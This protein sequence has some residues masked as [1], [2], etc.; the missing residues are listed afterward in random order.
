[1]SDS[2][3]SLRAGGGAAPNL[4]GSLERPSGGGVAAS[5]ASSATPADVPRIG[6]RGIPDAFKANL[7]TVNQLIEFFNAI[8]KMLADD[9]LD[10]PKASTTLR[11]VIAHLLERG[12][13]AK[14]YTPP[15]RF[16]PLAWKILSEFQKLGTS[17]DLLQTELQF[18]ALQVS[19]SIGVFT[20]FTDNFLQVL[21]GLASVTK[22]FWLLFWVAV[23]TMT[24]V[25]KTPRTLHQ[26]YDWYGSYI[27]GNDPKEVDE[28]LAAQLTAMNEKVQAAFKAITPDGE[29]NPEQRRKARASLCLSPVEDD[30]DDAAS[31]ASGIS[32]A[33]AVSA[34]S[35]GDPLWRF[36]K[37]IQVLTDIF[38]HLSDSSI[39]KHPFFKTMIPDRLDELVRGAL[40]KMTCRSTGKHNRQ[41]Y[42]RKIRET[43]LSLVNKFQAKFR[44]DL[45][46][47]AQSIILAT[48]SVGAALD[49]MSTTSSAGLP[50]QNHALI[51]AFL[52]FDLGINDKLHDH[53]KVTQILSAV[54]NGTQ[55]KIE[56]DKHFA[57][58]AQSASTR[59]SEDLSAA[60]IG[61]WE[62]IAATKDDAK[63]EQPR[64]C[65][66][67]RGRGGGVRGRGGNQHLG[68]RNGRKSESALTVSNVAALQQQIETLQE[69]LAAANKVLNEKP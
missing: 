33:S 1:M 3:S 57:T 63:K 59:A 48:G 9:I 38:R 34:S 21:D 4:S 62:P 16:S 56:D 49:W 44:L 6:F 20:H 35:G 12:D 22:V 2:S 52:L 69:Q 67:S 36:R 66:A 19:P 5:A 29:A 42:N 40:R 50:K 55:L 41:A 26:F 37:V 61:K 51:A 28:A 14:K 47:T 64:G 13:R 43:V 31:N 18:F 11:V 53:D 23:M 65:T 27:R 58:L 17:H 45:N 54:F 46:K 25:A 10:G 15:Q 24:D 30:G 32:A 7:T 60:L 68:D 39:Q 8:T